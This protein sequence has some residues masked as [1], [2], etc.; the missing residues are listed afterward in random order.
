[1]SAKTSARPVPTASHRV[2]VRL[3]P[4]FPDAEGA[5][6][7][8]LLQGLGLT[9]AREVRTSRLY[10]LKGPYTS[11]HAQQA[12][13]ELLC[14]PVTQDWRLGEPEAVSA[15]GMNHWRVEVWLKET[16]TDPVGE[17]VAAALAEMGLPTPESVRTGTAYAISGRCHRAQLEKAV[18]RS[19]ANPVVHRVSVSESHP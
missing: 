11:P 12:A 15:N 13:K 1:M 10:L 19:L 8:S 9:S 4:E 2:E 6:A 16:V 5:K 7:L 17:T 3:R 14:D 18:A